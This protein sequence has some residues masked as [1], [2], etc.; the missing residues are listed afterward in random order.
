MSDAMDRLSSP[1][2]MEDCTTDGFRI[3]TEYS[4]ELITYRSSLITHYAHH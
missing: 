2:E 1:L 3:A 4:K